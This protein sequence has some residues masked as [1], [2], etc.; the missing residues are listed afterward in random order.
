M[1]TGLSAP[2]LPH[3]LAF[4]TESDAESHQSLLWGGGRANAGLRRSGSDIQR[5]PP[6]FGRRTQN[7]AD[8]GAPAP[9]HAS[10]LVQRVRRA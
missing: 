1:E 9:P 4:V 8:I 2:P 3:P 6:A 5:G 7:L 10:S